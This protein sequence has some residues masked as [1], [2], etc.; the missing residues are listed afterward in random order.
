MSDKLSVGTVVWG[1][2][3]AFRVTEPKSEGLCYGCVFY[4]NWR[5]C[6]KKEQGLPYGC[7]SDDYIWKQVKAVFRK[8]KARKRK[9]LR[10]A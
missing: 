2:T 8:D 5:P 4:N 10:K 3:G 7:A 9:S 6:D 1:N